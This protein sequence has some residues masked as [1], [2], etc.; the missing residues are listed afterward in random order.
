MP[1]RGRKKGIQK[2][3]TV[4]LNICLRMRTA[5]TSQFRDALKYD[6]FAMVAHFT[7]TVSL[8][9]SNGHQNKIGSR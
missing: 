4:I 2:H 8:G 7:V 5:M 3:L 1:F 6:S 9:W